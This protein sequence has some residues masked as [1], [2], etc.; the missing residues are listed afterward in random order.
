MNDEE[1]STPESFFSIRRVAPTLVTT[2]IIYGP[3]SQTWMTSALEGK[4]PTGEVIDMTRQNTSKKI[5]NNNNNNNNNNNKL[6]LAKNYLE[7]ELAC[8]GYGGHVRYDRTTKA[9]IQFRIKEGTVAVLK[10]GKIRVFRMPIK[11]WNGS[12]PLEFESVDLDSIRTLKATCCKKCRTWK[13]RAD[14]TRCSCGGY[15]VPRTRFT[16]DSVESWDEQFIEVAHAKKDI[17]ATKNMERVLSQRKRPR[18]CNHIG[19]TLRM[20]GLSSALSTAKPQ[21]ELLLIPKG[22]KLLQ[23]PIRPAEPRSLIFAATITANKR[24]YTDIQKT[25][26]LREYVQKETQ[27]VAKDGVFASQTK[28]FLCST[29]PKEAQSMV[30]SWNG[31]GVYMMTQSHGIPK[32]AKGDVKARKTESKKANSQKAK[33]QTFFASS[34]PVPAKNQSKNKEGTSRVCGGN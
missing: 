26:L 21:T 28:Q 11:R 5:Q 18:Q 4:P 6:L 12:L 8:Q 10:E 34:L 3:R 14:I 20:A 30:E 23:I 7:Q 17:A 22:D 27:A 29:A 24:Q 13:L 33:H 16:V 19:M 9:L 32:N 15:L 31:M 2:S 1:L 25:E